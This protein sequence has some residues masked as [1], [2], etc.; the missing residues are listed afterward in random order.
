MSPRDVARIAAH[1]GLSEV[2]V[3]S[4][5]VAASGDRLIDGPGTRC[6]F[7][8][9]G[10]RATCRIYPVRPERCRSW[11]HWPELADDEGALLEAARLCPGI[12]LTRG[13]NPRL[14]SGD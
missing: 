11:P 5:Y 14:L 13:R 2:A 3:R 1:L 8:E 10:C 12:Q 9:D 7:L 4:L 6:V